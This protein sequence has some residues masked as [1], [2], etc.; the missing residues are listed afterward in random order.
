MS[1][2]ELNAIQKVR[3]SSDFYK[4]GTLKLSDC[5]LEV[6]YLINHILAKDF[7]PHQGLIVI[8]EGR[9]FEVKLT[10]TPIDSLEIGH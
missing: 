2:E 1:K 5:P 4:M 3:Y 10:L 6:E 9:K 8:H 7:K